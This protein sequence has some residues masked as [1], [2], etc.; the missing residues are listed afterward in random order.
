MESRFFFSWLIG[1][2][3]DTTMGTKGGG[4][5]NGGDN[6]TAG[7]FSFEV[8]CFFFN[9]KFPKTHLSLLLKVFRC[10]FLE[11]G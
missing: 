9:P 8:T 10:F 6:S 7:D 3:S 5:K 2:A 11:N 1:V 4:P